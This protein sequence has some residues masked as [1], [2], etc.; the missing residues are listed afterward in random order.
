MNIFDHLDYW[1]CLMNVLRKSGVIHP[2]ASAHNRLIYEIHDGAL[3][4]AISEYARGRLLDIGCSNKPYAVMLS[5]YI[6]EH[7]GV[8]H[9]ESQ[10]RL[11]TVDVVADAYNTTMAG[12]SFDTVLSTAV[13]EHLEDPEKALR[14]AY[15]VLKPGGY[16]IYTIPLFWHLHEEPRDFFRFT[17]Y[18]I[19]YL[20][21]KAGFEIVKLK[22]L[23]GFWVT[24]GTELNYY[25]L[26]HAK[27][28]RTPFINAWIHIN[29]L[30]MRLIKNA[31]HSEEWSWMYLVVAKK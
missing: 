15:H 17:K 18:G 19:R 21:E 24:F 8:D 12:S 4:D 1:G 7:I 29:N 11:E 5:P 27:G 14:E 26:A 3:A 31:D 10:H 30:L 16:A 22:P 2:S 9:V 23:S 28:M 6:T 20:F 25:L 13:L